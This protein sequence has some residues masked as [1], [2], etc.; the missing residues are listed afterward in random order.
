MAAAQIPDEYGRECST[1]VLHWWQVQP[2]AGIRSTDDMFDF[3]VPLDVNFHVQ[4]LESQ[5]LSMLGISPATNEVLAD[6]PQSQIPPYTFDIPQASHTLEVNQHFSL[7][8]PDWTASCFDRARND[9]ETNKLSPLYVEPWLTLAA[10]SPSNKRNPSAGTDR[11][12]HPIPL[13]LTYPASPVLNDQILDEMNDSKN[14]MCL[15]LH[16]CSPS[17]IESEQCS[18]DASESKSVET[19]SAWTSETASPQTN[20]A[21]LH[22][23]LNRKELPTQCTNFTCHV[24]KEKFKMEAIYRRHIRSRTCTR[25]RTSFSCEAC[26]RSFTLAKDLRRHLGQRGSASSCPKMKGSS[27]GVKQFMCPC[28]KRSYSRKDSLQ[29]HMEKCLAK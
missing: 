21:I 3:G 8:S 16:T 19:R 11:E 24:C 26:H 6:S 17:S 5:T 2:L 14:E 12:D 1:D 4:G 13:W 7:Q 27:H 15:A 28:K 29:R 10:A 22:E 9:N 18:N 25:S 23:L 20:V